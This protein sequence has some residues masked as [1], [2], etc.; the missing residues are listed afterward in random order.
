MLGQGSKEPSSQDAKSAKGK[1]PDQPPC[2]APKGPKSGVL[3]E[4]GVSAREQT[5]FGRRGADKPN[6]I[7][8]AKTQRAQRETP[9]LPPCGAPKGPRNG[10]LGG[11]GVSAREQTFFGRRGADKPNTIPRAKT[12]RAQNEDVVFAYL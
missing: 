1:A 2:G 11:L 9:E 10:F 7:P 5:F 8:R 4:L 6:T 3:C 12:Q